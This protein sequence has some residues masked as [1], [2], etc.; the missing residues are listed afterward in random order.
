ML[1]AIQVYQFYHPCQALNK[2]QIAEFLL[3]QA[4]NSA[5]PVAKVFFVL[6]K[7]ARTR[8]YTII[9]YLP[10]TLNTPDT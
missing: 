5:E 7:R 1:K 8:I 4:E 9:N 3:R 6:S 10:Y 2:F